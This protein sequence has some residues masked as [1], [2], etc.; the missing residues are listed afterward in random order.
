VVADTFFP[1]LREGLG[2]VVPTPDGDS[3]VLMIAQSDTVPRHYLAAIRFAE[4]AGGWTDV[5]EAHLHIWADSCAKGSGAGQFYLVAERITE[6]WDSAT[7]TGVWVPATGS[8]HGTALVLGAADS[9]RSG[10]WLDVD[11]TAVV[12]AWARGE[13]QH[14]LLLSPRLDLTQPNA[15]CLLSSTRGDH[16]PI[17]VMTAVSRPLWLPWLYQQ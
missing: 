10:S 5:G 4:P 17:L 14:G 2:G 12:R 15:Y 3:A 1:D 6:A 7:L 16:P 8:E 9:S 11:V 13:P